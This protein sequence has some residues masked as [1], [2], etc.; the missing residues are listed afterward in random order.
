MA[1]KP[2]ITVMGQAITVG[3]AFR[4]LQGA[5]KLDT[6]LSTILQQHVLEQELSPW[7]AAIAP[8]Q[9][10]QTIAD[11]RQHHQLSDPAEF[12]DWLVSEGL[13]HDTLRQRFARELGLRTLK[14]QIATDQLHNYFIERKSQL[15]RVVL[16]RIVVAQR[17][18]AEE[19]RYQLSDGAVFEAL[20]RE[21][22]LAGD[23]H[24]NGMMGAIATCELPD[25]LRAALD[26][27]EAGAIVGPVAVEGAWLLVRLET[28]LP[29]TLDDPDLIQQL[30][31]ELFDRWLLGKLQQMEIEVNLDG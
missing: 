2:L 7:V 25:G 10:E 12:A 8:R 24:M 14:R 19:L 4:Y 5:G 6:T 15:D 31:D 9:I 23:R 28:R 27:V 20:A 29:A 3:Q 22:S 13:D 17:D 21:Y 18:L 16:S 1:N 30:E 26:G 11:F